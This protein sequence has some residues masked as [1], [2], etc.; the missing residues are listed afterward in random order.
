MP[1]DLLH[2]EG[3]AAGDMAA[4]ELPLLTPFVDGRGALDKGEDGE[5]GG[6]I[7]KEDSAEISGRG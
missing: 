4:I 7:K 2:P 1:R 3:M 5:E 6:F